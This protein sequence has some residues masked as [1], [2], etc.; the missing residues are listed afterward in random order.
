M[1]QLLAKE[2]KKL[3][4]DWKF[5]EQEGAIWDHGVAIYIGPS[6]TFLDSS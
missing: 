4:V 1:S 2:S 6:G 5:W 3:K